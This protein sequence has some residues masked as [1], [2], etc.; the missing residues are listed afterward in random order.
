MEFINRILEELNQDGLIRGFKTI[1]AVKDARV[2]I[3]GRWYISFCS[4][5][6]LGLSQHPVLVRAAIQATRKMGSGSGASRLLAGTLKYHRQLEESLAKFKQVR[7][8]LVFTSGY[9]A[10]L[11][12][13]TALINRH[14]R[15]FC[16]EFNHASLVDAARLTRARLFV[17]KHR[18]MD[19]LGK[20]LKVKRQKAK[21]RK[22]IITDTVFSMDGDIAPLP[23]I[24]RLAKR[25]NAYTIIDEAHGTGVLGK[26]GHGTAEHFGVE[27]DIDIII[28]TFSKALGS[29]GGFVTG[30]HKFIT[31]LKTK[32]RPFI[33]TTALPPGVC[34]AGIAG[35]KVIKTQPFL[36]ERLWQNT[37]YIKQQLRAKG[38]DLRGSET[39]II[40]ILIGSTKQTLKIADSLWRKGI[41]LP[42]IRPPTVP[43]GQG[44]LRLT[45]TALHT[46]T[47]LDKLVILLSKLYH[48]VDPSKISSDR[49]SG[50]FE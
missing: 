6:Y 49:A 20:K 30:S 12:V 11:A 14:D 26:R 44:R 48:L 7:D 10:N 3:A 43:E 37:N 28:G 5:D 1:T 2:K 38:F 50:F 15:I 8:A 36:R 24:V 23:D 19:D 47:E 35:L 29:L 21:S 33:Y 42:A 4:N 18:D 13:I 22:F 41:F 27:K 25:Y 45:I 32:S 39:P 46:R 16:D 17:Y 31:Y 34:A 40:P 9:I